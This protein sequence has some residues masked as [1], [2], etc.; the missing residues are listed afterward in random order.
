[1]A[2]TVLGD[3][4]HY[5]N[6][7]RLG[8]VEGITYRMNLF[9]SQSNGTIIGE[10]EYTAGMQ[11]FN[12]FFPDFGTI[13]RRDIT[14][15]SAQESEKIV[16]D[17][18]YSFKTFWKMRPQEF[19]QAAFKTAD[20]MSP[21]QVYIMIGRKLAEHKLDYL[22]KQ[23]LMITCAALDSTIGKDVSTVRDYTDGTPENFTVD[24]I[25]EAMAIFGDRAGAL[26]ALVM[27]S[28]VFFPIVKDQMLNF[29]FDSGSGVAIYGGSP[30]TYGLPVIVT[31][32]PELVYTDSGSTFYKTLLLSE[33]AVRI[34]DNGET[35]VASDFIMGRENLKNLFQAEGDIWNEVK[36]YNYIGANRGQNPPVADLVDPDNWKI[37]TNT[38]KDT[39]GVLI[40]SKGSVTDAGQRVQLVR[41][42]S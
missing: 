41:F 37:W 33:R 38:V 22:V 19:Q 20:K 1:M 14:I 8:Y 24:K 34:A 11:K 2:F 40:K 30:A 28:A 16:R 25:P 35:T 23:A 31:D 29:Q 42:E 17:E 32:N 36:G 6:Y 26:K 18:F 10:S 21:E 5:E 39:A 12:A 27:H 15:D 9:N 3:L 13:E 4:R 7:L